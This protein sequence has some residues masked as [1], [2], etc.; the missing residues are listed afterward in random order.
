MKVYFKESYDILIK[1][2]PFVVL[3]ICVNIAVFLFTLVPLGGAIYYVI[4]VQSITSVIALVIVIIFTLIVMKFVLPYLRYMIKAG[5]IACIAE[6]ANT[7]SLANKGG[8]I[9][10]GFSKVK[11][12]FGTASV[13]FVINQVIN[14]IVRGIVNKINSLLG[15]NSVGSSRRSMGRQAANPL[16]IISSLISIFLNNIDEAVLSYIFV[17]PDSNPWKG[18]RDGLILYFKAWKP[19]LIA[20]AI[21]AV[22]GYGFLLI[23]FGIFYLVSFSI[24]FLHSGVIEYLPFIFAGAIAILL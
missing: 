16:Q 8:I 4:V 24:P 7:G 17:H 1:T 20:S 10:H 12:N 18:A 6:Y 22:I 23:V 5:H 19:L 14:T 2:L 13:F 9:S 15:L 3:S 21:L 11:Q